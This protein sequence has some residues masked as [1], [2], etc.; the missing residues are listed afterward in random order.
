MPS[1]SAPPHPVQPHVQDELRRRTCEQNWAFCGTKTT[2]AEPQGAPKAPPGLE[3]Q[4]HSASGRKSSG[5]T[6]LPLTNRKSGTRWNQP[7]TPVLASP[8]SKRPRIHDS[9]CGRPLRHQKHAGS[10][11]KLLGST[12]TSPGTEVGG[13]ADSPG[14]PRNAARQFPRPGPGREQLL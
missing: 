2:D 7:F 6:H 4:R 12:T 10:Q 13:P 14:V 5:T 1:P 9:F 8:C 3:R 11:P